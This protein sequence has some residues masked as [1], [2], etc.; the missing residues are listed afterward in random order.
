MTDLHAIIET[1]RWHRELGHEVRSL[2]HARLIADASHLNVWDAN[3]ADAVSAATDREIEEVL[4]ALDL[5]LTHSDWRVVHTDP[6]TPEAFVA[7]LALDGFEEQPA[8]I[9]MA[10]RGPVR[11]SAYV[12]TRPAASDDDWT[13]VAN[14]VWQDHREGLRTGNAVMSREVSEG[15]VAGYRAKAPACRFHLTIVE[16]VAVGY[17]SFAPG[18]RGAGIIE[19]LYPLPAYRGRGIAS[20]MI[21]TFSDQLYADGCTIV[22]LGARVETRARHLYANLGFRPVMLTRTWVKRVA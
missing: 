21:C 4:D 16:G 1:S 9:Q 2:P 12:E 20:A 22:F 5:H 19:D 11:T 3:H 13:T 8:I 17:G 18:P 6:F 14:L 7:R 10:L 15:V